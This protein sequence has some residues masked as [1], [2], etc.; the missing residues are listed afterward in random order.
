[1]GETN[2]LLQPVGA[3]ATLLNATLSVIEASG[4]SRI[5]VVTGH[6][7]DSVSA[8]AASDP[9]VRI[10]YNPRFELGMGTSIKAGVAAVPSGH[11]IMIWPADMPSVRP[12][13]VHQL[14]N[15]LTPESVVRPMYLDQPG[16]PVLFGSTYLD[17]LQDIPDAEGAR[18]LLVHSSVT[19]LNV[20]DPGVVRDLDIP[21]DFNQHA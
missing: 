5:V 10:V 7:H 17:A 9:N 21:E 6:Q 15:L 19:K 16:H 3:F 1:M 11:V 20:D 13:T 14:L 18:S 12:E 2:K 4:A 8:A